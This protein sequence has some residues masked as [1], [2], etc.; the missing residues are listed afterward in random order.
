MPCR[1]WRADY[2][3]GVIVPLGDSTN[4]PSR[5]PENCAIAFR[6]RRRDEG[7]V[8]C[9][10]VLTDASLPT[11]PVRMN[12]SHLSMGLP[13][14]ALLTRPVLDPGVGKVLGLRHSAV[15]LLMLIKF[16]SHGGLS[17]SPDI[18]DGSGTDRQQLGM[19]LDGGIADLASGAAGRGPPGP[20]TPA[21][22]P[23]GMSM[24]EDCHKDAEVRILL[25]WWGIQARPPVV[26]DR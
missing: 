14:S 1:C 26:P 21:P 11:G 15:R 20:A 3:I 12:G 24:H 22:V 25:W 5:T 19:A 7:V 23:I 13:R 18:L 16:L 10:P 8:R 17:G 9:Q 4:T 6:R 2:A